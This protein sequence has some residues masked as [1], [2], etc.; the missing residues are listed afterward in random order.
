MWNVP[1]LGA[2]PQGGPTGRNGST[3]RGSLLCQL[4]ILA[5][6]QHSHFPHRYQRKLKLYGHYSGVLKI[7]QKKSQVKEKF[8]ASVATRIAESNFRMGAFPIFGCNTRAHHFGCNCSY[9]LWI[10]LKF[11][12]VTCNSCVQVVAKFQD[13][14]TSHLQMPTH[15]M[16]CLVVNRHC[17]LHF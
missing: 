6:S 17:S 7:I 5:H 8:R 16:S 3:V 12:Y 2:M 11:G 10:D 9:R 4:H 1:E 13:R 15:Q 14:T